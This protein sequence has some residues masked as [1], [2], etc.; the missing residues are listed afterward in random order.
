MSGYIANKRSAGSG[1]GDLGRAAAE[2]GAVGAGRD[3]Q[4][5]LETQSHRA[6]GAEARGGGD[7]VDRQVGAFEEGAGP[8][9]ALPGE[10]PTRRGADL[11]AE[12]PGEGPGARRL[13]GGQLPQRDGPV[14]VLQRPSARP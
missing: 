7:L 8:L 14:Q 13:L 3:A 5:G 10:P 1:L 12:A 6:G 9:D 2:R 11:L 4:L